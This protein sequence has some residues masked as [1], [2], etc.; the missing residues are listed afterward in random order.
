MKF[1]VSVVVSLILSSTAFAVDVEVTET[2]RLP[3]KN[4]DVVGTISEPTQEHANAITKIGK[5]V[6][7]EKK[8]KKHKKAHKSNKKKKQKKQSQ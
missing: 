2:D 6:K 8:A 3:L 7:K 4:A 5:E 1:L